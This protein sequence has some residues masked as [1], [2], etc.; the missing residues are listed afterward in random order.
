VAK[1]KGN[2]SNKTGK[3]KYRSAVTGRYVTSA[4]ARRHPQTTVKESKASK[5]ADRFIREHPETFHELSK[6]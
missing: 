1:S 2:R 4:H 3:G 5:F 6:R